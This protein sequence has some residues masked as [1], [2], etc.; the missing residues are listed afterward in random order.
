[1]Q[2]LLKNQVSKAEE[3]ISTNCRPLEQAR[4]NYLFKNGNTNQVIEELKKFQNPDGG[5]GNGLEPDFLLPESSPLASSLAFQFLDEIAKPD[6]NVLKKAIQYFES[7]FVKDRHGWFAV[8]KEVNSYPHAVWWNW[9]SEK[10]QTAIDDSWGNPS[11]EIIG[12]LWKFQGYVVKLD[13]KEL[14]KHAIDYWNGKTDFESEHEAYCFVRLYKHLSPELAQQ[15]EKTLI[16]AT[17]KLVSLDPTSWSKYTPQ[18]LHFASSPD[19]FLYETVKDAIGTNLDYLINSIN[20]NGVWSPNW[21]W[22]Q[23]ETEWSQSKV[24]WEG[25]LTIQNLKT[26]A[27]YD[28]IEK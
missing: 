16:D 27:A 3:Y 7:S 13:I 18:P 24:K 10:R 4:F 19:F 8:P 12:Y 23:Y 21:T 1:M 6:E 22:H 15:L 11:A 26:L 2:K 25:I 14:A 28:R 20:D 17:K 9:D 5:F